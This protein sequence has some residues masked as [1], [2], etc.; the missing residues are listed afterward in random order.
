[1]SGEDI[2]AE[3][4]RDSRVGRGQGTDGKRSLRSQDRSERGGEH[5]AADVVPTLKASEK[6]LFFFPPAVVVVAS[7]GR[8]PSGN[9]QLPPY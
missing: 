2:L 5:G 7:S 3:I 9:T 8:R 4:H 1:M 6:C